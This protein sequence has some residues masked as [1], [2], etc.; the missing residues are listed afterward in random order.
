MDRTATPNKRTAKV[1]REFERFR[2]SREILAS[3]YERL[4]PIVG[5]LAGFPQEHPIQRLVDRQSR[6]A[7]RI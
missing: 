4:V 3:A 1:E 2:L 7:R 5:R 6:Q